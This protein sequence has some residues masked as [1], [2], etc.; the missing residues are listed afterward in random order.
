MKKRI[1]ILFKY[2][3]L[4][5]I[6]G[7]LYYCLELIWRDGNSHYSMIIV[8]GACGIL[9]GL[10]NEFF[11]WDLGLVQQSIIGATIVTAI[12]FFTGLVI[13]V[14]LHMN[15]WDYSYLPFNLMGQ[16]CLSYYLLWIPLACGAI[17]LDDYLRYYLFD[18]EKPHYKLI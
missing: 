11:P 8:S 17:V 14:W 7:G 4:F 1:Q 3:V 2:I 13:N 10:I 5:V 15:V 6:M 16:V 18:E 12:E 9:I